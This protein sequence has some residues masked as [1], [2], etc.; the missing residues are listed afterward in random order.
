MMVDSKIGS[1]IQPHKGCQMINKIPNLP[2]T[3]DSIPTNLDSISMNPQS[4]LPLDVPLPQVDP[5]INLG[6]RQIDIGRVPEIQSVQQFQNQ[7][8]DPNNMPSDNLGINMNGNMMDQ[9]IQLQQSLLN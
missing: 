4:Q 7:A 2:I 3:V 1:N 8:N 5:Q 6:M 9:N